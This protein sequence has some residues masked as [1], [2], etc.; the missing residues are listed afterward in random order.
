M[1]R[2]F[3]LF[4]AACFA[5]GT[6]AQDKNYK[7]QYISGYRGGYIKGIKLLDNALNFIVV[8]DW[9]RQG[10]YYQK[11]VAEQMANAAVSL[12]AEFVVS[13]GDNFYPDGVGSVNDPLWQTSFEDVY[14]NFA[15]QKKWYVVLG[16][17]DYRSNPQAQIDYGKVSRRWQMPARYFSKKM[18][19]D[20]DTTSK[21]LFVFIDTSPFVSKY[22]NDDVYGPQVA[23]Q[24]TATQLQWLSFVLG[25]TSSN[26]KWRIVVGHH[27]LYSGGKRIDSKDTRDIQDVFKPIFK[28]YK[29]DMYLCGHE[30]HLE[31]VKAEE[32]THYFTSGAG[33]EV[34]PVSLHPRYGKFASAQAGFMAF[35]LVP[36]SARIQVINNKGEVI[37]STVI[38]RQ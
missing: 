26:I 23:T 27:P 38:T 33:S 2:I 8:G 12:D 28:K 22:Y 9:G 21:V 17:H 16:N 6:F 11:A 31:Y 5:C 20:D 13:T 4:S 19:I 30:H 14:K 35:S 32:S 1:K 15:L 10:E 18:S 37:H 34:R 29:V 24:D 3:F 36:D 25:D 7:D